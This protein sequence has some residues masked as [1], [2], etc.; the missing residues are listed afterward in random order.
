M[1]RVLLIVGARRRRQRSQSR[2]HRREPAAQRAAWTIRPPTGRCVPS[3]VNSSMPPPF[4]QGPDR[5]PAATLRV[6]R[7][8]VDTI[9][10]APCRSALESSPRDDRHD[11]PFGGRRLLPKDRCRRATRSRLE[12]RS[13]GVLAAPP[14]PDRSAR[15][16]PRQPRSDRSI[17]TRF[18]R[19]SAV[20]STGNPYV[21][22]SRNRHRRKIGASSVNP[23]APAMTGASSVRGS[24]PLDLDRGRPEGRANGLLGRR[25]RDVALLGKVRV[26]L[27]HHVDHDRRVSARTRLASTE[28]P[29]RGPPAQDPTQD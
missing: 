18:R 7:R 20:S 1:L 3:T 13:V 28:H 22:C 17:A 6:K 2:T 25:R 21:S 15:L 23:R 5:R 9:S 8:P 16:L 12:P 19:S 24:T 10:A 4:A 27:G 26:R 14:L 11:A 29:G